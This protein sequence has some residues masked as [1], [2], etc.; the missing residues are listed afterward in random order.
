ML[1]IPTVWSPVVTASA[2][3]CVSTGSM[4]GSMYNQTVWEAFKWE[5]NQWLDDRAYMLNNTH[6]ITTAL[7]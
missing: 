6:K 3:V 1:A 4:Y 2:K 7:Q 5:Q